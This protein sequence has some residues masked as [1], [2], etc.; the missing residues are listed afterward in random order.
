MILRRN[1][2][3]GVP[4]LTQSK[5]VDQLAAPV[6]STL[7]YTLTVANPAPPSTAAAA[8]V[9][10]HDTPPAGV[11]FVALDTQGAGTASESGGVITSA[12][13]TIPLGAT[14]ELTVTVTVDPGTEGTTLVNSFV[15]EQPPGGPPPGVNNPCVDDPTASCATTDVPGVP[16]L[17]YGRP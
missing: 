8:G 6:G 3:P 9:V 5:V 2:G 13:G 10:A 1:R 15:V 12:I 14:F 4:R 11:T 7:T 17:T 16:A